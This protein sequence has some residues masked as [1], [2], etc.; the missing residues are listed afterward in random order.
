MLESRLGQTLSTPGAIFY[1]LLAYI[2]FQQQS[3][4]FGLITIGFI[5]LVPFVL[6]VITMYFRRG[7]CHSTWHKILTPWFSCIAFIAVLALMGWEAWICLVMALPVL[8]VTSSAGG[9]LGCVLGRPKRESGS[10]HFILLSLLALPFVATPLEL[11]ATRPEMVRTVETTVLINASPQRIWENIIRVRDIQPE[12]QTFALSHL[13]GLPEPIGATL[14]EDRLGAVREG[15]FANGL[16]FR[17]T[18]TEWQPLQKISFAI[19]ADTSQANQTYLKMIGSDY[20]DILGGTYLLEP[21]ADGRIR[22]SF[23][24]QHRLSTNFNFYSGLWSDFLIRDF[25]I[26]ILRVIKARVEA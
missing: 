2:I 15:H 3:D 12:D 22:L 18:I 5:F 17:E 4:I 20:V 6:G 16:L 10:N 9:F 11:Q 21:L 8:L 25:Q 7:Y 24:S 13:L 19:D 26:Y 1:G 14:T 23:T